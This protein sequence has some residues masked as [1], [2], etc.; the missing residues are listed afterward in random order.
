M[1]NVWEEEGLERA[2]I[3][4]YGAWLLPQEGWAGWSLSASVGDKTVQSVQH[5]TLA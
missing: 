3:L 4:C 2:T 1:D 5:R